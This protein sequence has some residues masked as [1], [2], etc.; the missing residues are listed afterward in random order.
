VVY[1]SSSVKQLVERTRHDT[2]RPLLQNADP[3]KV[4]SELMK[5]REPF[6]REVADIVLHTERKSINRVVQ[7]ILTALAQRGWP[8]AKGVRV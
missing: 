2:A 5:I 7:E 1:L 6:Y 8:E 3:E 4:L